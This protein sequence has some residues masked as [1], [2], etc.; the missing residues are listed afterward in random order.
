MHTGE[1]RPQVEEGKCYL[2]EE[3]SLHFMAVMLLMLHAAE[4]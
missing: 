2:T 4:E 1:F 3:I